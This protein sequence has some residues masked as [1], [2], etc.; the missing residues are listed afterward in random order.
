VSFGFLIPG[1]VAMAWKFSTFNVNGIRARVT[2]VVDWLKDREPDVL[3]LQ[4]IKCQE[5]DF[6]AA[7]FEEAGYHL[8]VRGQKGFN[9]VAILT[10]RPLENLIKELADGEPD[11]EARFIAGRVDGV[12]VVNTYVPQGR[13]PD[14]P[15]FQSKLNYFGR[16]KRWFQNHCDP[17]QP[18]IWTGDLNV[19][20]TSLDVFDPKRLEG[21]VGFHPLEHDALAEVSSWGFVDCFRKHHPDQKQFT[22]WDYRLPKSF[23]RNLGWRLDHILATGPLA[24]VCLDCLVDS[25]LR[26]RQNPSDHTPVWAEFD[27]E[28]L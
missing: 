15:A 4:E 13:D 24:A 2:T 18:L 22:F 23:E 28:G 14:H 9:G 27:L 10:R 5:K 8:S 11:D 6:P 19:A 12:W 26:G 16:L 17:A 1:D 21:S 3:C 20:P 7:P 25:D